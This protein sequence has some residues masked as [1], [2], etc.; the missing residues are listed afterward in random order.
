MLH[1][2]VPLRLSCAKHERLR[3]NLGVLGFPQL[4][5]PT[6]GVYNSLSFYSARMLVTLSP[7]HRSSMSSR[8]TRHLAGFIPSASRTLLGE[9]HRLGWAT[10]DGQVKRKMGGSAET[11]GGFSYFLRVTT[12]INNIREPRYTQACMCFS[13]SKVRGM[14]IADWFEN[15]AKMSG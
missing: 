9:L 14:V 13:V 6:R 8:H 2:C 11:A 10:T 4:L 1:A 15:F 12:H 3:R 5:S 7:L